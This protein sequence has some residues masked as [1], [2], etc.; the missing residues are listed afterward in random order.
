MN[1]RKIHFTRTHRLQPVRMVRNAHECAMN[2]RDRERERKG[3]IQIEPLQFLC[4]ARAT[5]AKKALYCICM[6]WKWKW[7]RSKRIRECCVVSEKKQK[8]KKNK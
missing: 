4:G 6:P 5:R 1:W 2:S 8:R 7:K 3:D